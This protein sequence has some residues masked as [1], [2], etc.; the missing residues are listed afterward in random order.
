MANTGL[1]KNDNDLG[2]D[3]LYKIPR[4]KNV[5]LTAPYMHDGSIATLEEVIDHYSTGIQ[6][7]PKL[8]NP[9]RNGGQPRKFN[10]TDKQKSELV[11][12]LK[13]LSDENLP[14]DVK[15]SSPFKP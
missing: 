9:L 6:D 7:N 1:K 14:T 12:F 13:T 15:F 5:A 11:A 2:K 10:F 8:S 4:L 3:G